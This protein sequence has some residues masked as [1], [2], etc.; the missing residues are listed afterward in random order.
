MAR[1]HCRK[2]RYDGSGAVNAY[3]SVAIAENRVRKNGIAE[4]GWDVGTL[5]SASFDSDGMSTFTYRVRV[6][7]TTLS[8]RLKVALA[9]NSKV[10]IKYVFD[11]SLDPPLKPVLDS[12]LTLDFDL[13]IYDE[14]DNIVGWGGSWDNSY[15]ITE[16]SGIS[17]HRGKTYTIKIRRMSGTDSTWFGIAWTV[18]GSLLAPEPGPADPGVSFTRR[19]A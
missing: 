5:S 17:V 11:P 4:R 18:Y 13:E 2:R 19:L 3:E 7:I 8:P 12:W 6:P 10:G 15:E 9:W 1:R 16:I 14:N